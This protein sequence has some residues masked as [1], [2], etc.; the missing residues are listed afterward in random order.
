MTNTIKHQSMRIAGK[1]VDAEKNIN[2]H[3]PYTNEII[4]TVPAGSAEHAKQALDIATLCS[5]ISRQHQ[6]NE[7]KQY[8]SIMILTM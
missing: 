3:Y 1:K 8:C 4:G 6:S 2:V 5:N 7:F